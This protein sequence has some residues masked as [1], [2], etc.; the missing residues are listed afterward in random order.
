MADRHDNRLRNHVYPRR[1]SPNVKVTLATRAAYVCSNPACLRLTTGPH[2]DPEKSLTTGHAAHIRAAAKGGPRYDE[3]QT[4]EQR[5][6]IKNG[7]WLCRE[8]GDIVDKDTS[9]H[10]PIVLES[11]KCDHEAMIAEIRSA[12]YSATLTLLHA[13]KADPKAARRLV[14]LLED[15]RALWAAFDAETPG[16]VRVSLDHLRRQLVELRAELPR[17]SALDSVALSLTKTIHTFFDGVEATDFDTLR[18][19]AI[20]PV[21]CG[22][23]DALAALRKSVALQ[24]ANIAAAY[25]IEL[26]EDL[27]RIVPQPVNVG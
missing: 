8:C 26:S 18:C 14:A 24:I 15:R 20:D 16:R 22:F 17:G 12:G 4:P 25:G 3:S 5:K 2:S 7:I 23:R 11:W 10:S 19:D 6:S 13:E 1:V 9:P 27:K 21:W